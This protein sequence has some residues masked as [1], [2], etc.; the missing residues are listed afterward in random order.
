MLHRNCQIDH[1]EPVV[2]GGRGE[3]MGS[4]RVLSGAVAP[5]EAN[6]ARVSPGGAGRSRKIRNPKL[7]TRKV[8]DGLRMSIEMTNEP[9]LRLFGPKMG[10]RG[11]TKPILPGLSRPR[12]LEARKSEARSSKLE[13]S[14]QWKC[15]KHTGNR[16]QSQ[17]G[18]ARAKRTQFEASGPENGGR[19]EKQSQFGGTDNRRAW[20]ALRDGRRSTGDRECQ[21]NPICDRPDLGELCCRESVMNTLLETIISTL[22][23]AP[24]RGR[25]RERRRLVYRE[26]VLGILSL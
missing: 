20:P 4:R 11:K 17:L 10:A 22:P 5:N 8:S 14:S 1:G 12:P 25:G 23:P 18:L 15:S 21:T 24:A 13:T 2:S 16:K 26:G 6:L 3:S 9:N 7:E 19:C